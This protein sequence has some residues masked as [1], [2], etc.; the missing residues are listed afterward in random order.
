M[1]DDFSR[2]VVIAM[3][4]NSAAKPS[5]WLPSDCLK[6]R[7]YMGVALKTTV[8]FFPIILGNRYNTILQMRKQN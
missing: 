8:P 7:P 1:A 2:L 5:Q 4:S 6:R 3:S